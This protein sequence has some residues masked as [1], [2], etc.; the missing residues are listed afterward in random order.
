MRARRP[1]TASRRACSRSQNWCKPWPGPRTI[2]G[3]F[4]PSFHRSFF[5]P[6]FL[7]RYF[8]ANNTHIRQVLLVAKVG[9]ANLKVKY[10][11]DWFRRDQ[12][13]RMDIDAHNQS[14]FLCI[15]SCLRTSAL[16][17]K[18]ILTS[19]HFTS[20]DPAAATRTMTK[21]N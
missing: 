13:A 19:K 18:L 21:E 9:G 20:L 6:S 15:H 17:I 12:S 2:G 16:I 14:M 11:N 7:P 3:L 8:S 1:G 10:L 5:S 4:S